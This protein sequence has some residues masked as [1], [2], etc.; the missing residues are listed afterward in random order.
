MALGKIA[1]YLVLMFYLSIP[2]GLLAQT[3]P[4]AKAITVYQDPG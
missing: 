1:G 4:A 3:K 2:A